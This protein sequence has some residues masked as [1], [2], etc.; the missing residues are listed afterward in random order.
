MSRQPNSTHSVC[1]RTAVGY[2]RMQTRAAQYGTTNDGSKPFTTTLR[3][4]ILRLSPLAAVRF[5][6]LGHRTKYR[7]R[8]AGTRGSS[9]GGQA[10]G[11]MLVLGGGWASHL[12]LQQLIRCH[13]QTQ[14]IGRLSTSARKCIIVR[15]NDTV[16]VC[17]TYPVSKFHY[18]P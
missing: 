17:N 9:P 15:Q 12:R 16:P 2:R 8:V 3:S 18:I 1:T 11:L 7:W 10:G 13:R 6:L 5:L 14:S 4:E